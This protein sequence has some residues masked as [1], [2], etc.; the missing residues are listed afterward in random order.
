MVSE[1]APAPKPSGPTLSASPR[2]AAVY[3]ILGDLR[4]LDHAALAISR[5]RAQVDRIVVV[6]PASTRVRFGAALEE[7]GA[8]R[9]VEGADDG[10]LS[11]Y[12]AGL[13]ALRQMAGDAPLGTVVV[14]GAQVFGPVLRAEVC[15]LALDSSIFALDAAG[16]HLLAANWI[17]PTLDPRIRPRPGGGRTAELDFAV[18]SPALTAHP[19]FLAFWEAPVVDDVASAEAFT[20]MLHAA[21]LAIRYDLPEGS[22]ETARPA[23]FEVHKTL[24]AGGHCLP[25]AAFLLDPVLHDLNAILLRDALDDLRRIDPPLYAAAIRFVT[26]HMQPRDFATVAD[27][28]EIFSETAAGAPDRPRAFGPPAVFIHAFYATMMPEFWS[29]IVRLPRDRHLY[30]TTASAADRDAIRTFLAER[31]EVLGEHAQGDIDIPAHV[32]AT[33][34]VVAQNRG[35]DMASLFIT[36]RD[37]VLSGRH[38]VALRLHSKRTPQVS[39]Q[40]GEG[41]KAHLFDNLVA[42]RGYV[43]NL[44]DRMEAEPDIGLVI[45]PL[46]HI[47]LGTLGHSWFAN[48]AELGRLCER[49]GIDVPLDDHTPLAPNGTMYWFRCDA[50]RLLF[51]TDWAWT[52]YN[53]EPNHI[54]GGLAH[55]QERL[56]GYAAQ[57]RG[58]RILQVMAPG[59]AAR[60]YARLEYKLAQLASQLATGSIWQQR[61]QLRGGANASFRL[62]LYRKLVNLYARLI[63]R[64][65]GVHR[66]IAPTAHQIAR[67]LG[68]GTR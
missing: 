61:E 55:V 18:F 29:L 8:D 45:P 31:G 54:D 44:L 4:T 12:R 16:V 43:S 48:K 68:A 28:Y 17:D 62:T 38:E 5:L 67:L 30:L 6:T 66:Y 57:D 40:V 27:Q 35:R 33:V 32:T 60:G 14:T 47:G 36:W 15:D 24:R 10:V 23:V 65:P 7:L 42:S 22:G 21:N 58:F 3:T 46:I 59:P 34:R 63:V 19:A 56:I 64:H 39:R 37:V 11:G 20:A 49:L 9:V 41:F 53:E 13:A 26:R 2:S 1:R 25:V 50:L 51:E 52:D